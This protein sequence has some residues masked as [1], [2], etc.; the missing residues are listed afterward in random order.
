MTGITS[1][2]PRKRADTSKVYNSFL[3]L[4]TKAW[5]CFATNLM[6]RDSPTYRKSKDNMHM[7]RCVDSVVEQSKTEILLELVGLF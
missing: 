5:F 4:V 6:S 7:H 2:K 1:R 3:S